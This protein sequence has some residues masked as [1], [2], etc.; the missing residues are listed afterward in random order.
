MTH[1][2]LSFQCL[3]GLK[4]N[5]DHDDDGSTADG[6]RAVAHD[7]AGDDGSDCDDGQIQSTEHGD[8]VQNLGDEVSG[9]LAGTEAGDAAP[10]ATPMSW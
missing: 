5:T 10:A 6:Q 1:E 2:H 9:G 7:V 8:L 4:C 3:H